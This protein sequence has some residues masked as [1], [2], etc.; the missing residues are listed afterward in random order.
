MKSLHVRDFFILNTKKA[1]KKAMK[2]IF[3]ICLAGMVTA[4]VASC[5]G[6]QNEENENTTEVTNNEEE[7]EIEEVATI[8]GTY[9]MTDMV[10]DS[11]DKKLTAQDE[12]Y[13]TQSKERTVGHTTLILNEDGT[14]S[15]EF[16]HPSGDGTISKWTGTFDLDEEAGTLVLNAEMN[17]KKMPMNFTI[18]ENTGEKL[19]MKTD[20]GQIFM[21]YVYKK[22]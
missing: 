1:M 16:P 18:E 8:Y 20:F 12:K 11:G 15:R 6:E 13:I 22:K 2:N 17:G 5:G 14:F 4:S 10:P 9:S 7:E 3:V 21:V 19:S